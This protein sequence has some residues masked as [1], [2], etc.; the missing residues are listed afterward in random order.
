MAAIVV[1]G[2]LKMRFHSEKTRFVEIATL[3]LSSRSAKKSKQHLHF[4][5]IV[6]DVADVV[7]KYALEAIELGQHLRQAQVAFGC[8]QLLDQARRR[9][10]QDLVTL[11]HQLMANGRKRMRFADPRFACGDHI[12]CVVEERAAAQPLELLTDEGRKLLELQGAE[13]FVGWQA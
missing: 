10:P 1:I 2:S 7:Q 8:Q 13:G 3:R 9:R 6:L 4:V 12:D 11:Q 5:T